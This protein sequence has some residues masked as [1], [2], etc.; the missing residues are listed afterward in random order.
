MTRD[1]VKEAKCHFNRKA[2]SLI[3]FTEPSARSSLA[4]LDTS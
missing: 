4:L 2:K 1:A 3:F